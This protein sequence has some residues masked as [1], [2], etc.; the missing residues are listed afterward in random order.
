MIAL[1]ALDAAKD[2]LRGAS[3]KRLDT[4]RAKAR[5][6]AASTAAFTD[7]S[8]PK[9]QA[10]MDR[11]NGEQ[12]ERN[13]EPDSREVEEDMPRRG[14]LNCPRTEAGKRDTPGWRAW[15]AR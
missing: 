5:A 11:G 6:A 10:A 14:L 7:R 13:G 1:S 12:E 9:E 8:G 15:E 4:K 3:D 2:V